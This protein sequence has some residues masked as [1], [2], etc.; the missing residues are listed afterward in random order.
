MIFGIFMIKK[1]RIKILGIHPSLLTRIIFQEITPLMCS[2]RQMSTIDEKKCIQ[3]SDFD[4]V[5]C[6]LI[7]QSTQELADHQTKHQS[8]R[9]FIC[10][11]CNR[12]FQEYG[13]AVVH[14]IAI[15][16]QEIVPKTTAEQKR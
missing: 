14:G 15:H 2:E 12:M 13:Q 10:P 9:P 11:I 6:G 5:Y 1:V 3:M 4:C 7:F 16:S 8:E